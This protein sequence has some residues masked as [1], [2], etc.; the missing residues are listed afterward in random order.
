M[1]DCIQRTETRL[2][3]KALMT[4][5]DAV[6][7]FGKVAQVRA[8][9]EKELTM[10]N[11]SELYGVSVVKTMAML[12]DRTD[13]DYIAPELFGNT[14]VVF[15]EEIGGIVTWDENT[16]SWQ[17]DKN[18]TT[19]TSIDD[20]AKVT[21]QDGDLI[22]VNQAYRG[23]DF[24]YDST[25]AQINNGGTIINGWVRQFKGAAD[26][27]WFGAKGDGITD[28]TESIQKA[29]D[30]EL[31]IYF[32]SGNYATWDSL[33][34]NN[35]TKIIGA[36]PVSRNLDPR[37]SIIITMEDLNIPRKAMLFD[38]STDAEFTID[39]LDLKVNNKYSVLNNNQVYAY[40]TTIKN[41]FIDGRFSTNPLLG[42]DSFLNVQ[43]TTLVEDVLIQA[44]SSVTFKKCKLNGRDTTFN[45]VKNLQFIKNKCRE[46]H[47]IKCE[48][49]LVENCEIDDLFADPTTQA[50]KELYNVRN[51][52]I[53]TVTGSFNTLVSRFLLIDSC[54]ITRKSRDSL[55]IYK[56]CDLSKTQFGFPNSLDKNDKFF[57]CKI[58]PIQLASLRHVPKAIGAEN[59]SGNY[60]DLQYD[61]FSISG[62]KTRLNAA[63]LFHGYAGKIDQALN[64]NAA[65]SAYYDPTTRI[66]DLTAL[67]TGHEPDYVWFRGVFRINN[68]VTDTAMKVTFSLFR[69]DQDTNEPTI[70]NRRMW[71]DEMGVKL[72]ITLMSDNIGGGSGAGGFVYTYFGRIPRAKYKA[73]A[74]L[75]R[76]APSTNCHSG[77]LT[78][79][80]I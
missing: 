48:K 26:V 68:S 46:L 70:F 66:I 54:T 9:G 4:A 72:N 20:L 44:S 30:A 8:T 37:A 3:T 13:K 23:G 5:E 57:N 77:R 6:K 14:R 39:S 32:P 76:G 58:N 49:V 63:R 64:I 56:N 69:I 27:K 47:I 42:K 78:F 19:L 61:T 52:I 33:K 75:Y 62:E 11:A 36:K 12:N 71:A 7:G 31:E 15:V 28:D 34:I 79:W 59:I 21:G 41:S 67:S 38:K 60:L 22:S 10:L 73:W 51:C 65:T 50:P 53:D 25:K 29:L 17:S 2:V 18:Q 45:N 35:E 80:G 16:Q 43:N 40:N 24:I 55:T 74:L 1:S